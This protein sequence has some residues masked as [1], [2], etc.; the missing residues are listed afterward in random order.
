MHGSQRMLEAAICA[1][2]SAAVCAKRTEFLSA[3]SAQVKQA[4]AYL[5]AD[6]Q[7]SLRAIEAEVQFRPS[8]DERAI[9]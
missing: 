5:K 2:N 9:L 3:R 8:T 6:P 7:I 1:L 4:I